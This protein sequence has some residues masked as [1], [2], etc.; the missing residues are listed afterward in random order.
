MIAIFGRQPD[1]LLYLE[2]YAEAVGEEIQL[3]CGLTYRLAKIDG[4]D[5][6]LSCAG[7]SNYLSAI[8]LSELFA[9]YPIPHVIK[10]GDSITLNPEFEIG[11]IVFVDSVYP[12]AVNYHADGFRYGEIPGGIPSV[13]PCDR[14]LF[15]SLQ[16]GETPLKRGAL[17]SGE[18]AI[19]EKGEFDTIM[20]RRYLYVDNMAVYNPCSYGLALACHLHQSAFTDLE[21]VSLKAGDEEGKLTRKR[22]ALAKASELGRL[23][24]KLL[25]GGQL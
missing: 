19:Y 8:V 6:I 9:L 23:V 4:V 1:D 20:K 24:C 5:V 15:A 25:E 10:I 3:P 17:M 7:E 21:I 2:S 11:D 18:K 13:F 14:S 22:N 16:G 12:H